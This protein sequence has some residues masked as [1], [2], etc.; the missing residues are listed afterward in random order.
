MDDGGAAEDGL[1]GDR[2]VV[3]GLQVHRVGEHPGVDLDREPAGDLLALGRPG[4]QHQRRGLLPDQLGQ[5]VRGRRDDEVVE[6]RAVGHVYPGR[7]VLG[8]AR[9][10]GFRARTGP[11][12]RR[13]AEPAGQR[14]Q[15]ERDL[16]DVLADVL[17]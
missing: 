9:L 14:D 4:H 13:L 2:A 16:L 3:T 5:Q 12:H 1:L 10:A 15:L 11:H 8:T 17:R 7:S 6:V